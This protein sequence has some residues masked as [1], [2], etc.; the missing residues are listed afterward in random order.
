MRLLTAT[1]EIGIGILCAMPSLADLAAI[2]TA[3]AQ[4]VAAAL[5][6]AQ[7]VA[8]L[9][10]AIAFAISKGDITV[11]YQMAGQQVTRSLEQARGLREYYQ[12]EHE[13]QLAR[14][15]PLIVMGVEFGS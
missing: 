14:A 13:R 10:V 1:N 4:A 3:A 8:L 2:Q 6:P 9:D 11:S 15:A 7:M 5:T 12:G